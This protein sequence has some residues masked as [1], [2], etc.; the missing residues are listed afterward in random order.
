MEGYF[1]D[2]DNNNNNNNNN[3]IYRVPF[4]NGSMALHKNFFTE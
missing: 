4:P 3:K 1:L 2:Q